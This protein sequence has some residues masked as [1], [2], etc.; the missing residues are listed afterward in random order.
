[1]ALKDAYYNNYVTQD[2][3][4][5]LAKYATGELKDILDNLDVK[6]AGIKSWDD[7]LRYVEQA[8]QGR[9]T[10]DDV[11]TLAEDVLY[12]AALFDT[13]RTGILT[14]EA[15]DI[16]ERYATGEIKEGLKNIDI[17]KE[18]LKTW[19]DLMNFVEKR[20]DGTVTSTELN[21]YADNLINNKA[22]KY[23]VNSGKLSQDAVSQLA[24]YA[25]GTLKDLLKNLDIDKEKITTWDGLKQYIEKKSK[26]EITS[27]DL[28]ALASDIIGRQ[29]LRRAV[30]DNILS[31]EAV[32]Y[33]NKFALGNLKKALSTLNVKSQGLKTWDDLLNYTSNPQNG[34]TRN[35]VVN[36]LAHN[37][38]EKEDLLRSVRFGELSQGTVATLKQYADGELKDIL[39]KTNVKGLGLESWSDLLH[40]IEEQSANRVTSD[41]VIAL[42]QS[43]LD[44]DALR[45]ARYNNVL[46]Q[47]AVDIL[48]SYATGDMKDILD[49][50][51]V[52][53]LGLKTWNDLSDYI[54]KASEGKI[55][56]DDVNALADSILNS[57]SDI[58]NLRTKIFA[59]SNYA[60]NGQIFKDAVDAVEARGDIT[61]PGE[62]LKAF[63]EEAKKLGATDDEIAGL[64]AAISAQADDT[65]S[66]WLDKL[67]KN[68]NDKLAAW[69]KTIDPA[70]EGIRNIEDLIKYILKNYKAHG[71]TDEELF[72]AFA[73]LIKEQNVDPYLIQQ[74]AK[75]KIKGHGCKKWPWWILIAV[76]VAAGI[77]FKRKSD[78]AK[79]NK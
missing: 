46:S 61:D 63:V 26:G 58:D 22:L 10:A 33:L 4:D 56:E 25:D 69:L 62:W 48:S 14:Q 38:L 43:I 70:K 57:V 78:K 20:T 21:A 16:L 72:D 60:P 2:A 27:K 53:A 79:K 7:L 77:Y 52:D 75:S 66:T 23:A 44:E 67:I 45:N 18:G 59:Y 34:G 11:N 37:I 50:I 47:D 12:K 74:I 55:T 29:A 13:L 32:D 42:A 36:R 17:Y 64:L 30:Y 71:I 76:R 51:D 31:Q 35:A 73:K 8:S 41:Y 24:R 19:D 15:V 5:Y 6:A 68:S 28:D 65:V 49:G 3:V 54:K 1:Q 39:G 40:H 9:V